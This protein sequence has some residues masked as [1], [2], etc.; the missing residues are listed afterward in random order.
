MTPSARQS[1]KGQ[2]IERDEQTVILL[3]RFDT[4]PASIRAGKSLEREHET[5]KGSKSSIAI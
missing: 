5:G 1:L 3:D 2:E 4:S